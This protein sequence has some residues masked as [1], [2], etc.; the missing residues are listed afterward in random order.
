MGKLWLT[1]NSHFTPVSCEVFPS[2]NIVSDL[3]TEWIPISY[4][5]AC[6]KNLSSVSHVVWPFSVLLYLMFY[7]N[8]ELF[9][10]ENLCFSTIPPQKRESIHHWGR[11]WNFIFFSS[12][13]KVFKSLTV[14]SEVLVYKWTC[15]YWWYECNT[16]IVYSSDQVTVICKW[17]ANRVQ[18]W[19]Q[20]AVEPL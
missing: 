11:S 2:R 6:K 16:C 20:S 14:V 3:K 4:I 9:C 10:K 13:Y 17:R 15:V 12:Q 5:I 1:L 19:G 18:C 8:K 7:M